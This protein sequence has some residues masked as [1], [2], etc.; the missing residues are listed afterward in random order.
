M[1]H[2]CILRLYASQVSKPLHALKFKR[3]KVFILKLCSTNRKDGFNSLLNYTGVVRILIGFNNKNP[4]SDTRGWKVTDERSRA[5]S[6]WFLLLLNPQTESC[7]P[8]SSEWM[9]SLWNLRLNSELSPALYSSFCPVNSLPV[10]SSPVLGL[11][12][13]PT[14]LG[15]VSPLD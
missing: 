15:S 7:L 10:S 1:K 4:E 8:K 2:L 11:N 14:P 13:W 5:A 3:N 6:Y 12:V 9:P